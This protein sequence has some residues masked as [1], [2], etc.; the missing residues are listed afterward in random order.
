MTGP[1]V[2][3]KSNPR[4][5]ADPSGCVVYLTGSHTWESLQDCGMKDPPPAF[6]FEAYVAML[7]RH[8]HNFIRLWAWEQAAWFPSCMEKYVIAPLA[9]SRTGPGTALDGK[10]KFD[11]TRLDPE[12]FSRLRSRVAAAGERGIYVSVMLFQGWSIM[13]KDLGGRKKHLPGNPWPGHPFNRENNVNGVDGDANGNGEGEEVHTLAL[14]V[15]TR[16][17]E[18]YIGK[19]IDTVNDLDNVLYEVTNESQPESKDWQYHVIN[20]VHHY[21]ATKPKRHPVGISAFYAG[22]QG[23]M[24]ALYAS[25][26][27]WIAPQTEGGKYP[28]N[29]DPPAADGRKVIL[30]DTD[31]FGLSG[32]DTWFW[33]TFTRGMNPIYM[34]A[35]TNPGQFAAP[36]SAETLESA[37]R[38]MGQA[39]RCAERISLAAMPP[40]DE[41]SS[42][43]YCLA[44]EGR[45]Y[46]V[47]QPE[48]GEVEVRLGGSAAE[49]FSA[50]WFDAATG[51]AM[52]GATVNGGGPVKFKPP[53]AG[54]SLLWLRLTG[55]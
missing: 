26:A 3:S 2:V 35:V 32:G 20:Y 47:Y 10:P 55:S 27:E 11:L 18:A 37:R 15:V 13:K 28:Y 9:Y 45:E 34:D 7:E 30:S 42:T 46:L 6:D 17:Q 44:D 25:P 48:E 21:E 29:S 8:G 19:V 12:Y 43:R 49:A 4:Y 5:F 36:P 31:H 54:T 33:R 23:S 40:H 24:D 16:L 53:F 1:L 52:A 38:A 51:Q 50:E 14:P 22:R 41:L 39:R